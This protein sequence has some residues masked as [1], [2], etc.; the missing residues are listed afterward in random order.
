M[1]AYAT[2][3]DVEVYGAVTLGGAT[4]PVSREGETMAAFRERVLKD[5]APEPRRTLR[6]RWEPL[7]VAILEAAPREARDGFGRAQGKAWEAFL[8]ELAW[9]RE[10]VTCGRLAEPATATLW[11]EVAWTRAWSKGGEP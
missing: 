2:R 9:L 8:V 7:L 10:G 11:A 5:L 6:E 4:L 1:A 3:E